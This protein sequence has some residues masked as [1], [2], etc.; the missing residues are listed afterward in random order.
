MILVHQLL[1]S[2]PAQ[3]TP[4]SH[5]QLGYASISPPRPAFRPG[6]GWGTTSTAGRWTGCTGRPGPGAKAAAGRRAAKEL[7]GARWKVIEAS[8]FY[9]SKGKPPLA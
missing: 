1:H 2:I 9:G 5:P 4:A 7:A 6:E 3:K 8:G